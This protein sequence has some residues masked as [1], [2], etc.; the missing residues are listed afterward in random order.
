[1]GLIINGAYAG[2]GND[3]F[4]AHA[5]PGSYLEA[6]VEIQTPNDANWRRLTPSNDAYR[7]Y[8]NNVHD[9]LNIDDINGSITLR[10][11]A[12]LSVAPTD[13]IDLD[14]QILFDVSG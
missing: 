13:T 12:A 11:Q 1:V 2:G 4:K 6:W 7:L 3:S 5:A 10:I 9:C 14:W 8:Q